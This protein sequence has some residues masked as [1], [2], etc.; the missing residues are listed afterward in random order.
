MVKDQ[1]RWRA[2][3]RIIQDLVF[4]LTVCTNKGIGRM[5]YVKM[6]IGATT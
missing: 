2:E 3:R 4:R 1:Q 5:E 6:A